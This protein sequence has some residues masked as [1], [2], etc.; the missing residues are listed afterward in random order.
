[1]TPDH[2][3]IDSLGT[4]V[5]GREQMRQGWQSYLKMVPDYTIAVQ[6]TFINESVVVMLGRAGG[7]YAPGGPLLPEN[8]W[9]TPVALRAVVR[10]SLIAEWRVYA[11]N[12]P[13]R[14]LMLSR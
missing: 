9:Q 14:R 11:D 12:E 7:T 6:E 13:M 4:K 3:F 1:M 5:A 8:R 10:G 2:V